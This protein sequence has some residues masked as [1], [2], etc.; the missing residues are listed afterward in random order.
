MPVSCAMNHESVVEIVRSLV[1]V[2]RNDL[3]AGDRA[4]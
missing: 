4:E 2:G 1:S 3:T